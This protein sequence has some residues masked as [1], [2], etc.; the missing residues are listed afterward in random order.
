MKNGETVLLFGSGPFSSA[1]TSFQIALAGRTTGHL[2]TVIRDSDITSRLPHNGFCSWQFREMLNGAHSV[3][4]DIPTIP[5]SPIIEIASTYK[6]ARREAL[7]F[8]YKIENGKLFVCSL[9]LGD[10]DPCAKYLKHLVLEY[11]G[12]E[13]F[14]PRDS[15]SLEEL[16][17]LCK[18]KTSL[19]SKNE[20][21][22]QNKN[23]ITMQ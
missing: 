17:E 16:K 21:S 20:N 23:D 22:A 15:L 10:N 13:G 18:E 11:V 5:F 19:K 7:M 12:S 14:D 8:E 9:N 4:L 3:I 6:N 2:A 1:E